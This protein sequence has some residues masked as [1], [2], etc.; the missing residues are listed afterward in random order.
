[1]APRATQTVAKMAT[2]ITVSFADF[3]Q[4]T[5]CLNRVDFCTCKI[6]VNGIFTGI[7]TAVDGIKFVT[8][9]GIPSQTLKSIEA[10]ILAS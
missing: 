7:L 9:N 5:D 8:W 2:K 1:M 3:K 4:S 6:L 10:K